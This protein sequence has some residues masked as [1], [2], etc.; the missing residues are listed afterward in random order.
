MYTN[1]GVRMKFYQVLA[2]M[3]MSL[4]CLNA[5]ASTVM[6]G[7]SDVSIAEAVADLQNQ[8]QRT[9]GQPL[10]VVTFE[11]EQLSSEGPTNRFACVS[12]TGNISK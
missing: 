8:L 12:V 5:F 3:V 7:K 10:S 9:A 4:F 2:A 11:K 6:C 1:S